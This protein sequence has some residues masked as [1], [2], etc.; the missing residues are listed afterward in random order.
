MF[1]DWVLRGV[2]GR[3]LAATVMAALVSCGG[4]GGGEAPDSGGSG[5]DVAGYA[6]DDALVGATVRVFAAGALAPAFET[7]TGDHGKFLLPG[8]L[9]D[10]TYRI[11]ITAGHEDLD[12][13][14]ATTA[15][16]RPFLGTLLAQWTLGPSS[17]GPV[18][19]GAATT[20]VAAFAGDRPERYQAALDALRRLAPELL[21]ID[22]RTPGDSVRRLAAL[23]QALGWD[24]VLEELGDDGLLN[25]SVTA[26]TEARVRDVAA[27]ASVGGALADLAD[28]NLRLCVAMALDKPPA[29]VSRADLQSLTRLECNERG[30]TSAVGLAQAMPALS[31]LHLEDN[32]LADVTSIA[33]L[34]QLKFLNVRNNRV[35]TLAPLLRNRSRLLALMVA[36]N[37]ISDATEL[38]DSANVAFTGYDLRAR[39]QYADCVKNGAELVGF[40]VRPTSGQQ[41]R[42]TYRTTYNPLADCMVDWGDGM[43]EPAVCDGRTHFPTH[44][45]SLPSATLSFLVNGSVVRSQAVDMSRPQVVETGGAARDALL[46][47]NG[48][49]VWVY[50]SLQEVRWNTASLS[51]GSV[52]LYVLHDDPTSLY[53]AIAPRVGGIVNGRRWY[54][55]ALGQPNTG[56]WQGDPELL[57]GVGN[58]YLILVVSTTNRAEFDLSD[59]PFTLT[60]NASVLQLPTPTGARPGHATTPALAQVRSD[61]ALSWDFVAGVEGYRV[62]I[63]DLTTGKGQN[64]GFGGDGFSLPF[65]SIGNYEFNDGRLFIVP[66][67]DYRWRVQRTSSHEATSVYTPYA[68]FSAVA[69]PSLPVPPVPVNVAPGGPA[70]PGPLL[71][72]NALMHWDASEGATNYQVTM[73]DIT[74]SIGNGSGWSATSFRLNELP[75]PLISGHQYWWTVSACNASGCSAN[76]PQLR[77]RFQ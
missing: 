11:E 68:Y 77:F 18:V 32:H 44:T 52:D 5:R 12:G 1:K 16:R 4:G 28:L 59:R 71:G 49:E 19:V 50:G 55:F 72:P 8:S 38:N 58:G 2:V 41:V 51:G 74:G 26:L 70:A 21:S 76:S 37:C 75:V 53:D 33:A 29:D 7:V 10:G 23:Q 35:A 54:P 6:I 73:Y 20:G 61:E 36:E 47:P 14:Q 30:I 25:G 48:G 65:S 40:A 24:T 69:P 17:V 62:H 42:L 63:V 31:V 46:S 60:P 13:L 57:R 27:S 64:V 22:E 67:H 15:D 3:F 34:T 66:G 39:R 45:Y 56:R 9:P 43:R